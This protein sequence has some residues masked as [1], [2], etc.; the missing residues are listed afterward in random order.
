MSKKF[1]KNKDLSAKMQEQMAD[2]L[3]AFECG[4]ANAGARLFGK[5]FLKKKKINEEEKRDDFKRRRNRPENQ[6]V[7]Y[8]EK[9]DINLGEIKEPELK[10]NSYKDFGFFE[11]ED[12]SVNESYENIRKYSDIINETAESDYDEEDYD[13]SEEDSEEYD[14]YSEYDEEEEEENEEYYNDEDYEGEKPE[15]VIEDEEIF[16][17]DPEGE[18][19]QI[20]VYKNP[21]NVPGIIMQDEYGLNID[22]NQ[23]LQTVVFNDG[24]RPYCIA[25]T[26]V[27]DIIDFTKFDLS[28]NM[29][30]IAFMKIFI[31]MSSHPLGVMEEEE[32]LMKFKDFKNY[33]PEKF[34]F[35]YYNEMVFLYY[36][37]DINNYTLHEI[38]AKNGLEMESLYEF[39]AY[40]CIIAGTENNMFPADNEEYV[41]K[42]YEEFNRKDVFFKIFSEDKATEKFDKEVNI[43]VREKVFS[44]LGVIK[45]S[46]ICEQ[47]LQGIDYTTKLDEEDEESTPNPSP[48]G[49]QISDTDEEEYDDDGEDE[50]EF[51]LDNE[52]ETEEEPP[53]E[54]VEEEKVETIKVTHE[55]KINES[56]QKSFNIG[57]PEPHPKRPNQ[58]EIDDFPEVN[59]DDIN[60][61]DEVLSTLKD[62]MSG[63]QMGANK[64]ESTPS[65]ESTSSDDDLDLT[66][67]VFH[68]PR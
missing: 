58:V 3:Y 64:S 43:V 53:K 16:E 29:E 9:L 50:G 39:L 5:K 8:P 40:T 63:L 68:K 56:P 25:L 20:N 26:N 22:Y 61:S 19:E 48:F 14:E 46:E 4:M 15:E 17:D 10:V 60:F 24:F 23:S 27:H 6:E 66:T 13:S 7:D 37:S 42:Y 18:E 65:Y 55:E 33:D 38:I 62:K 54:T 41:K 67:P 36:V 45:G 12:D 35:I 28:A 21:N 11:D 49:F 1:K 32:F 57:F 30:M 44:T 47:V 31:I 2:D 51:D 34:L 59:P 52:G